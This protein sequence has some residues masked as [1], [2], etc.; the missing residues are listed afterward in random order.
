MATRRSHNKTRLGCHQCKRRRIKCDVQ[1]PS[2]S[3]CNKR[4]DN[5]SF[6]LLA[7][8]S[9]LTTSN[10]SPSPVRACSIAISPVSPRSQTSDQDIISAT[11]P[12]SLMVF[13]NE[14]ALAAQTPRFTELSSEQ[15]LL[16]SLAG[17][18]VSPISSVDLMDLSIPPYLRL[19]D[20]WKDIRTQLPP[21]L[22]DV[23][24]HYEY[25][26]SLT[27]AS[28]DPAKAAWYLSVPEIA[29]DHDFLINCV[30]SVASLHMGRLH[31]DR[32]AKTSA[33][34]LAAARMNKALVKY[35][36][37]L[38]NIT[39][40][41]ATAL[42]ASATLTAVYLFRTS[43]IDME[44]LRASI[45][46]STTD[47]PTD[48]VDK[49]ISC[50]MRTI[51][52]LRGPLTVL[53]S[54]WNHIVSGQMS[55][56]AARTWWPDDLLPATPRAMDEDER[57]EKIG[58]LWAETG[59]E[60]NDN[61]EYLSQALL[62]LREVFSLISQ[63]TL[64]ELYSPMT[65]IPY[66]VDDKTV[67]VLTD[68]GAVFVWAAR[69]SREFMQLVESKNHGAL[70]ILAHY[71]ILPGRVRNVWWLEGLGADFVTA[72]AMALGRERWHLIAWPASVVGV[73]LQNAF[74]ARKDR[75][76]GTPDALHM[77]VI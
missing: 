28:D 62:I 9:R 42:F 57:L 41:N 33:N 43:A 54:G 56:V 74:E 29:H 69:I 2:C 66:S 72:V 45:P 65:A 15:V 4:G 60:S 48:V 34:A 75:L 73:E 40:D 63:L 30:L 53:M 1:H 18:N 77:A 22:Q 71:A 7:P 67:E 19:D 14:V 31:D 13:S 38:E 27:L 24:S 23:L 39:Q 35:R 50:A 46:P 51:W 47:P 58:E 70:V 59:L 44:N 21:R 64:P 26:T 6:L 37:E 20:P 8:T 49:M 17:P 25:T 76:E 5:C 11:S 55:S 16:D 32:A 61:R 3:N 36:I 52:G 12:D 68:R 10:T